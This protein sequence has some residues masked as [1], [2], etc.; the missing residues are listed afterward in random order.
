MK[1]SHGREIENLRI[2]VTR[3]CNLSC[4]Y[5]HR[6]GE[7][8]RN[9]IEMTPFQIERVLEAGASI[10][11]RKL[12]LTGGEPLLRNDIVDIVQRASRHM[13]E[14]SMAT[15]GILL[16]EYAKRLKNAGLNR[17]NISL[18]T[19]DSNKYER[20]TGTKFLQKVIEGID[21]AVESGLDPVKLNMVLLKGINENEVQ[22]MID[23]CGQR[24]TVLQIIELEATKRG[25]DGNFYKEHHCDLTPLKKEFERRALKITT[26]KMQARKKYFLPQEVE[27][28]RSMHNTEFC[29]HCNKLRIT[30]DGKLK[31]CLLNNSNN[32]DILSIIQKDN[33]RGALLGA[34]KRA[35]AIREPYWR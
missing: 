32:I 1:D 16:S 23:F 26:R 33:S 35:I 24:K 28:V 14:V 27:L 9:G 10:G 12:K 5:C 22:S 18:D 3:H 8:K 17:V 30:S 19:I 2:S 11:A 25:A 34:F 21:A 20:I 4:M 31:P 13:I 29:A 7:G 6:E 15:N